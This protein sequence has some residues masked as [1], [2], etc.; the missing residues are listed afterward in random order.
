MKKV[1]ILNGPNI[2]MTGI[3]EQ[4]VYGSETLENINLRVAEHAK[5]LEIACVFYQ[6][7]SEGELIDHIQS[8]R[9]GYDGCVINAGA[10]THYSYAIRDAIAAVTKPFVEVHMSNIHAREEFRRRSVIAE[11]CCGQIAGF[12]KIGYLLA[13]S[14]LRE[15]L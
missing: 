5:S 12:G 13:V 1:L 14:A 8:V 7:N 15:L 4:G 3:R 10:Y 9:D 6:S 11:V 2:N